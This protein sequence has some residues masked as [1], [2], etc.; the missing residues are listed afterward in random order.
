MTSFTART[1]PVRWIILLGICLLP[2]AAKYLYYPDYRG[3]DDAY[4]HATTVLNL[5]ETG[6]WGVNPGQAVNLSSSPLFVLLL[7][8]GTH[9]GVV[10][11]PALAFYSLI[12]SSLAILLCFLTCSH[13]FRSPTTPWW[14]TVLT[15]VNIHLWRWNGTII[16]ASMGFFLVALVYWW[17]VAVLRRRQFRRGDLIAQGILIGLAFLTRYEL[18][19][20]LPIIILT[21][22]HQVDQRRLTV[23]ALT[24]AGFVSVIL[25]W[26]VFS[27]FHFDTLLPTTFY[28]K[29]SNGIILFNSRI[30]FQIGL[31]LAS[32][33]GLPALLMLLLGQFKSRKHEGG[34]GHLPLPAYS[35]VALPVLLFM[36]YYL[37]VPSLQSAAR[38]FLPALYP[39][40]LILGAFYDRSCETAEPERSPLLAWSPVLTQLLTSLLFLHFLVGPVLNRFN[41]EYKAVMQEMTSY[42]RMHAS[43]TD[44]VLVVVDIGV[45]GYYAQ[46]SFQILDHGAL[47]SPQLARLAPE[48]VTEVYRPEYVLLTRS[49]FLPDPNYA[50]VLSRTYL[51]EGISS[52]AATAICTLLKRREDRSDAQSTT[53]SHESPM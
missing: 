35:L 15:A 20:L 8:L 27:Y 25:P 2:A 28:A 43:K 4:I 30:T 22:L 41:S 13:M 48:E 42:L 17:F 16:E 44:T 33:V 38:Y 10:G 47:A 5:V 7:Y 24:V 51:G 49:D 21:I 45:V 29:T 9:L 39:I 19:L 18:G 14:V 26:F 32:S 53:K 40:P 37:R 23:V 34:K 31:V 12:F 3:S 46:G 52:H 11:L 50:P 1:P 6:N 36:F